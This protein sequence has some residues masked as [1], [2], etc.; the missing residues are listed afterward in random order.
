MGD[1]KLTGSRGTRVIKWIELLCR[2]PEGQFVGQPVKLR[3]W[4]KAE[5][6]KIYDNPAGTRLAI[7]S[8]G[9][10]NAKSTMAAFLLLAHLCGPEAKYN[11]QLCS[12]AQRRE[13]A[14]RVASARPRLQCH[15]P[16][17]IE[18]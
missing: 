9:R 18:A 15:P 10:K 5:I 16:G 7:I 12:A 14:C 1:L 2:I 3:P 4:Q 8:F 17:G 13:Q 11:G 6:K